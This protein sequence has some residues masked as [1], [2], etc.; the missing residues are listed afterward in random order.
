MADGLASIVEQ[1]TS[2]KVRVFLSETDIEHDVSVE[3][4]LPRT[5]ART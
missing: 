4:F 5:S 2:R 3:T 1:A